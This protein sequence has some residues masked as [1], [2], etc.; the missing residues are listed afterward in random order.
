MKFLKLLKI[1]PKTTIKATAQKEQLVNDI[2]NVSRSAQAI[3]RTVHSK[4]WSRW[5]PSEYKLLKSEYTK[6]KAKTSANL[7]LLTF[8]QRRDLV[9]EVSSN[10][11]RSPMSVVAK[12]K[13]LRIISQNTRFKF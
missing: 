9:N 8:Q 6:A 1:A 12:L 4:A 11:G 3:A 7:S 2:A 10:V 5:T 13:E